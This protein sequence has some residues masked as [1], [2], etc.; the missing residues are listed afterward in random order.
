VTAIMAVLLCT[1]GFA[2]TFSFE[3]NG[4]KKEYKVGTKAYTDKSGLKVECV[5]TVH[6]DYGVE[7]WVLRFTN[8][9]KKNS[10]T[11]S[12]LN[13][14]NDLTPGSD[15]TLHY[16]RGTDFTENDFQCY[17]EKIG[18]EPF[19]LHPSEHRSSRDFMPFFRLT[20][21]ETVK[22]Y[23]IGWT[24]EW[25]SSFQLVK[26][27]LKAEIDA[28]YLEAYLEPGESI[29]T[30][31]ILVM[32]VKTD[33]ERMAQNKFKRF[34]KQYHHP[35]D[36]NGQPAHFPLSSSFDFGDPAP[37]DE[38]GAMDA[39]WGIALV[40]RYKKFGLLPEDFW[41]DA[42]WY[43]GCDDWQHGNNWS[44]SVGNWNYRKD[45][46]PN[47]LSELADTVHAVGCKFILWFEPERGRVNTTWVN[48]HPDYFIIKEQ[49]DIQ[50]LYDL[51]DPEAL[52]WL[53]KEMDRM[54]KEHH[55]DLYRQDYNITPDPYYVAKDKPGRRGITESH[56]IEGLYTYWDYLR[57]NNPGLLIDNCASGGHRLDVE[58]FERSAPLW[59]S[60]YCGHPEANQTMTYG[61]AQW[62]PSHGTGVYDDDLYNCRSGYSSAIIF[63]WQ[64]SGWGNILQMQ[65]IMAEYRD[66][67]PYYEEDFYP[68]TPEE[69]N[70]NHAGWL[71]YQLDKPETNDGFIVAFRRPECPDADVTVKLGGLKPETTYTVWNK[72]ADVTYHLTGAELASGFN[73][74]LDEP[75]SSVIFRYIPE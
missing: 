73:I 18:T 3:L 50:H 57:D 59:R 38:Y 43:E 40:H 16:T 61:L 15:W 60:D 68:L 75:R 67:K 33:D 39:E 20:S 35:K 25:A 62:V 63:N 44:T 69:N 22:I 23:A 37:F 9:G 2:Q 36:L 41:L 8:T 29:R 74:H 58:T 10:P 66:M 72:D 14:M 51:S 24:G 27:G 71:A 21:P 11:I 13:V 7:E 56:Y 47:G 46:F 1:A 26:G 28:P 52:D 12:N 42:G 54:V 64:I 65:A 53:C 70:R 19:I 49:D 5:K 17:T 48:E 45:G 55:V 6:D 31:R 32:T 30:A 4:K 34:M